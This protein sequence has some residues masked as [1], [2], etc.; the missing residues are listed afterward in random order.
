MSSEIRVFPDAKNRSVRKSRL[1]DGLQ[2][3]CET[4]ERH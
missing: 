2:C 1:V 4:S 3:V